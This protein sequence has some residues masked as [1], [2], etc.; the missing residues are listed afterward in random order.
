[1]F[2]HRNEM[3]TS[4]G[5][6]RSTFQLQ[7]KLLKS[8]PCVN[9]E[10]G[11]RKTIHAEEFLV[12]NKEVEFLKIRLIN[13]Q[14]SANDA[15]NESGTAEARFQRLQSGQ[16][17]YPSAVSRVQSEMAALGIALVW[18]WKCLTCRLEHSTDLRF[19]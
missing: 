5:R 9:K 6:L 1:M 11:E 14:E 7:M 19:S 10:D 15:E 16:K 2:A 3:V 18:D 12:C 13:E 17:R 4:K 8:M